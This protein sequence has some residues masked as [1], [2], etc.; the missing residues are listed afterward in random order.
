VKKGKSTKITG[1]V[2][3]S[4]SCGINQVG[5]S[6]KVKAGGSF[7]FSGSGRNPGGAH[8]PLKFKGKFVSKTK[9]KG[10]IA[11][12]PA[13]QCQTNDPIP[14]VAKRTSKASRRA[15]TWTL[16]VTIPSSNTGTGTVTGEGINCPGDC[17]ETYPLNH[18]V[19][20]SGNPDPGSSFE[21]GGACEGSPNCDL[22]GHTDTHV[23]GIFTSKG[24]PPDTT[25]PQTTITK[26]PPKVVK[27]KKSKAPVKFAF[28]ASEAG[29]AFECRLDKKAFKPCK[30]P[31]KLSAKLGKH[32]FEVRATDAAGNLDV[33]PAKVKFKV[34]RQK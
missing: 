14:F 12:D 21:W 11:L 32:S 8:S 23:S 24:P 9:A 26:A 4:Y 28:K 16:T 7:N 17:T 18:G 6:I 22:T 19:S 33:T 15:N 1:L 3:T 30:S 31:L 29:A 2:Y 27:T 10:T 5:P 13:S 34:V 25:A 20:L